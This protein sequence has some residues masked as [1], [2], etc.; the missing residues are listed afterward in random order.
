MLDNSYIYLRVKTRFITKIPTILYL[1]CICCFISRSS[2]YGQQHTVK[3]KT[4]VKPGI[5]NHGLVEEDEYLYID[6]IKPELRIIFERTFND[7][8]CIYLNGAFVRKQF[9]QTNRMTGISRA[10][11]KLDLSEYKET[12]EISLFMGKYC[13]R[14]LPVSGK[15]IAYINFYKEKWAIEL[16][17]VLRAYK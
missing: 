1:L 11:I 9:I 6:S 8:V 13:A 17:N 2:L 7:T 16:S 4:S 14:F 10:M 5:E 12:P 15:R 3:C